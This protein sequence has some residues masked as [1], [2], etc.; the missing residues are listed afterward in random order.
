MAENEETPDPDQ[1]WRERAKGILRAE[2][3]RKRMD[4]QTLAD[5]LVKLGVQDTAASLRAKMFRGGFS[6]VFFLQVLTVLGCKEIKLDW[7]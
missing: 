7:L 2:M 5:E 6:A 1:E 3:A 4:Y